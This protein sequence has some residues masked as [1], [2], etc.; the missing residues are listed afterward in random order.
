MF[1]KYLSEFALLITAIIW[2]FAFVAQSSGMDH[3]GPFLFNGARFVLGATVLIPVMMFFQRQKVSSSVSAPVSE[4]QTNTDNKTMWLGGLCMGIVLFIGASLQQIGIQHTQ[5]ANAGFITSLYII[6]V[7]ILG[8]FIGHRTRVQTWIGGLAALIGLFLLSVTEQFQISYG[9][10]LQ[11][12]GAVFWAVH[13]LVIAHFSPKADALKLCI[14][15]FYFCGVASFVVALL[16]EEI[17]LSGFLSILP[18]IL[19]LGVL[20]TSIAY[21]FQVIAQKHVAPA[22]AAVIFSLESVFALLGGWLILNEVLSTRDLIGCTFMF[23]GVLVSQ[24]KA[25]YKT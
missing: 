7:P 3:V 14:I 5:V 20:S 21:T 8:L 4:S 25:Q 23:F 17:N 18:E 24:Y 13:I 22:N 2:G 6:F 9:D 10:L 12:I 19:Y 11:L 1:K 15:Q 16:I